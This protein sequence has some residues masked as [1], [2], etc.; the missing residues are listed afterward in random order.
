MEYTAAIIEQTFGPQLLAYIR[1]NGVGI[2]S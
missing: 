1:K 2:I